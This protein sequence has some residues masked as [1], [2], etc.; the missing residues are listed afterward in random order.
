[1]AFPG[2][3]RARRPKGA[4]EFDRRPHLSNTQFMTLK[5]TKGVAT[6]ERIVKE[7]IWVFARSGF[8]SGSF[9]QIADRC[10]LSQAA[11]L[12]HF[13]DKN[14]LIEEVLRHITQRN[15]ELVSKS[16]AITDN[17]RVRLMKHFRGNLEWGLKFPDEAQ[18]LLLVYYFGCFNVRFSK[19]YAEMLTRARL[20]IQEH[21]LAGQR[22]GLFKLRQ[23]AVETAEILHDSLL[24]CFVNALSTQSASQAS[25][26]KSLRQLSRKWEHVIDAVTEP[27]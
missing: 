16:S 18:T 1:M 15:H 17:A 21:L 13:K 20:R 14:L 23:S 7:A 22:E 6:R 19:I 24:G 3:M 12:Y 10:S 25:I 5:K 4:P 2:E 26:D 11:V 27:T 9:Q 8:S